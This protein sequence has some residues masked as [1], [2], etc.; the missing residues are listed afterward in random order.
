[1]IFLSFFTWK[2]TPM[3]C[4]CSATTSLFSGGCGFGNGKCDH[5]H[6]PQGLTYFHIH[7]VHKEMSLCCTSDTSLNYNNYLVACNKF[8]Q[9]AIEVIAGYVDGQNNNISKVKNQ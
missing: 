3:I 5:D 7:P 2:P 9:I 8:M 1:M 4:R 6:Q